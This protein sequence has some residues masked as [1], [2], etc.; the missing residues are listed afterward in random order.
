MRILA[1]NI[2]VNRLLCGYCDIHR[3]LTLTH[4]ITL[5]DETLLGQRNYYEKIKLSHTASIK[6]TS[7]PIFPH[8]LYQS[9]PTTPMFDLLVLPER[10]PNHPHAYQTYLILSR[11]FAKFTPNLIKRS[12]ATFSYKELQHVI[13][14]N[15]GWKMLEQIL[16]HR[17]PHLGDKVDD[18]QK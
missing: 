13:T 18:P 15:D 4:N 6:Q 9:D 7:T 14:E 8:F 12:A 10:S 5:H 16:I 3:L 1:N 17:A 11:D 2:T